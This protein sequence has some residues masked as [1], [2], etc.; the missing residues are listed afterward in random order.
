MKMYR[1]QVECYDGCTTV[2][3]ERSKAKS[4]VDLILRRVYSQLCG[5]NIKEI[6]VTPSV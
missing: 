3:Y 1:V 4:A 5:L 2:W 6:S